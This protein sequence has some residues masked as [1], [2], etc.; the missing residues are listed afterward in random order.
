KNLEAVVRAM[1][2][3]KGKVTGITVEKQLARNAAETK[4]F[5][6]LIEETGLLHR[7]LDNKL[8]E[9]AIGCRSEILWRSA[10]AMSGPAQ[11]SRGAAVRGALSGA[12]RR[13]AQ[14]RAHAL[15]L[16]GRIGRRRRAQ[17]HD[18]PFSR[19]RAAAAD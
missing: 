8:F 17:R 9:P 14:R 12:M 1:K 19:S 11:L 15:V 16:A 10:A 3:G 7:Y 5:I 18:V 6:E 13:G 2:S 4:R